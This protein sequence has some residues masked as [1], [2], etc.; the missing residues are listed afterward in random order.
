MRN[1]QCVSRREK[2][3]CRSG[4]SSVRKKKKKKKKRKTNNRIE[5]Y[6]FVSNSYCYDCGRNAFVKHQPVDL[7]EESR[8]QDRIAAL[9]KKEA[10][11]RVKE[12]QLALKEAREQQAA[13]EKAR[14]KQALI[15]QR[16]EKERKWAENQQ[17]MHQERIAEE[18]RRRES[19]LR[20]IQELHAAEAQLQAEMTTPVCKSP[21]SLMSHQPL[22]GLDAELSERVKAKNKDSD[23]EEA[24]AWVESVVGEKGER[25]GPN[26]TG[27]T[28]FWK[29]LRSGSMLCHLINTLFPGTITRMNKNKTGIS[30]AERENV[31]L[32]ISGCLEVGVPSHE[33][34]SVA[35]LYDAKFLSAVLTNL[36][37]LCRVA[38][39][40]G[41][42][43]P[44]I[45]GVKVSNYNFSSST[46]SK[47]PQSPRWEVQSNMNYHRGRQ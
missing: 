7:E 43:M 34:F 15:E 21:R 17:K 45:L 38:Q 13:E 18:Q 41:V 5:F 4:R 35:D 29:V 33:T 22:F 24:V 31:Q 8:L 3:S 25:R 32:Y 1:L 27:E 11:L 28:H 42:E 36:Y 46:V 39:A 26:E 9:N 19:M 20:R 40:K 23:W 6:S 44:S 2:S 10:D 30:L 12:E 47:K 14:Q 16:G 37:A